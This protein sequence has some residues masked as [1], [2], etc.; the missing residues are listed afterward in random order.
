MK[1]QIALNDAIGKTLTGHTSSWGASQMLLIFGDEFVCLEAKRGYENG[2]E[3]IEEARLDLCM[4]GDDPL[5]ES[6]ICTQD[7]LDQIREAKS[8]E[9]KRRYEY[10]EQVIYE[11][12]KAKFEA[13]TQNPQP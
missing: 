2:E 11:R 10:N 1:T 7:E 4:F 6:G 3:D 13:N 12:L 8:A 5:V 9:E